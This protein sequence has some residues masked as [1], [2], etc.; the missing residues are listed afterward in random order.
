M[1]Q[2]AIKI[3]SSIN[4][5]LVLINVI[6]SLHYFSSSKG[7]NK[8][9]STDLERRLQ[10]N[11]HKT[12]TLRLLFTYILLFPTGSSPIMTSQNPVPAIFR[13]FNEPFRL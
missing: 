12:V 10:L 3:P 4:T 1:I 6:Y 7:S 11:L 9:N 5:I 13:R 8:V 2:T